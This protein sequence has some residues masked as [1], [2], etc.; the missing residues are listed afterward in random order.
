M[1]TYD[2]PCRTCRGNALTLGGAKR[3]L[4]AGIRKAE[5]ER[6]TESIAKLADLKARVSK[7]QQDSD[8]HSSTH[9]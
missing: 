3:D 7:V 6:T 4:Y 5:R 1:G 9:G 8:E 2:Y